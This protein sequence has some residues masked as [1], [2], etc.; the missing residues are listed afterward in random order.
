MNDETNAL[1][2]ITADDIIRADPAI[3]RAAVVHMLGTG[4][5][6]KLSDDQRAQLHLQMCTS[7]GVNPLTRPFEW[8]EFYDPETRGKKLTLYPKSSLADQLSYVH[9]IRVRTVEEKMVGTLYKLVLE[10]TMPDGR[11]ETN[12]AYLDMVDREG[13]PLRGQRHGNGLMKARTKCKRRLIFGMVGM[14]MPDRDSLQDARTVVVDGAGRILDNPTDEERELADDPRLQ[15]VLHEPTYESTAAAAGGPLLEGLADQRPRPETSLEA[16]PGTYPPTR[17]HCD[18]DR[19]TKTWHMTARGTF[20]E[21]EDARHDFVG[22][23]TEKWPPERRTSSLSTFLDRATDRQAEALI[24]RARETIADRAAFAQASEIIDEPVSDQAAPARPVDERDAVHDP[25]RPLDGVEYDAVALRSFY[26][27]WADAL[28]SRDTMFRPMTDN[29]LARSSKDQLRHEIASL[30]GQC[31]SVDRFIA[32]EADAS[33]SDADFDG[34]S[35][36]ER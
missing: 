4:D 2:T 19:W 26:R 10:G 24:N 25:D 27:A 33:D 5:Y 15:R 17:F 36:T 30:I 34:E 14:S 35:M 16:P 8:I 3:A 11:S 6:S 20:L 22:W 9:R 13:K 7:L 29:A 21:D 23:Y 32:M 18:K 28:R 31:E 12:V 1:A